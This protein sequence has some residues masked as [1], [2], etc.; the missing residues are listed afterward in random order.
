VVTWDPTAANSATQPNASDA[1]AITMSHPC[2]PIA[3]SLMKCHEGSS[4]DFTTCRTP[5]STRNTA[6]PATASRADVREIEPAP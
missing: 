4:S 3:Y 5:S 6:A 2:R 1:K